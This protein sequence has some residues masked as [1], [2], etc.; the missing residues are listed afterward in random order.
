MPVVPMPLATPHFLS[1][2]Y[3]H[4]NTSSHYLSPPAILYGIWIPWIVLHVPLHSSH[5]FSAF[6]LL[7]CH[8]LPATL[9]SLEV[10][11]C[12]L[13]AGH[14]LSNSLLLVQSIYVSPVS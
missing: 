1:A 7:P 3:P 6:L 2:L 9:S 13:P 12:L 5:L 11:S 14:P 8:F 10:S 4:P